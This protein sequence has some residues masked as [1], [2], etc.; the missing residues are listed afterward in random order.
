MSTLWGRRTRK[1]QAI[2][3]LVFLAI[4]SRRARAAMGE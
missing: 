2:E 3:V 1:K 4:Y